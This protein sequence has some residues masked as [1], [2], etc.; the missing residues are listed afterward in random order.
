MRLDR[1]SSRRIAHRAMVWAALLV[2]VTGPLA[3]APLSHS[4]RAGHHHG[5]LGS[6]EPGVCQLASAPICAMACAVDSVRVVEPPSLEPVPD[7]GSS[8]CGEVLPALEAA[9]STA[10]P[11]ARS[12]HL[13]RTGSALIRLHCQYLD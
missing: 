13:P 2:L 1:T 4:A 5:C 8:S 12:T 7:P 11:G 3:S 6:H 10:G 9:V